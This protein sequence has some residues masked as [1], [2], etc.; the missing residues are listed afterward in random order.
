MNNEGRLAIAGRPYVLEPVG[1]AGTCKTGGI[2][3]RALL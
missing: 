3:A 2:K 1:L